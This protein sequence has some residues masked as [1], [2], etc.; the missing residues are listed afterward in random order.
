MVENVVHE[1]FST[2]AFVT[3]EPMGSNLCY[4]AVLLEG[5]LKT[6]IYQEKENASFSHHH[7]PP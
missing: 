3:K 4:A 1:R 6:N 5:S 2:K 7:I